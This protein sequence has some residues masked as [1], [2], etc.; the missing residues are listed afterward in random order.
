MSSA[1][2]YIGPGGPT[3]T[4]DD[5]RVFIT[6]KPESQRTDTA[7]QVIQRLG[8]TFQQVQGMTVFMQSARDI[9]IGSRLSKTQYQYTLTDVDEQELSLDAPK[10]LAKLQTLPQFSSVT[11]DQQSSGRR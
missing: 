7:D 8:K 1:V 9:T 11:R 6:L 5:G 10:L 4:K 2:G 3:V